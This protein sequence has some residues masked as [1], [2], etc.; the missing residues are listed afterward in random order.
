M[1]FDFILFLVKNEII[2]L[3][4]LGFI[5]S[6]SKLH[7]RFVQSQQNFYLIQDNDSKGKKLPLS[8]LYV[9]D[10]DNFYLVITQEPL[11]LNADLSIAFKEKTPALNTLTCNFKVT[12][13]VKDSDE[14]EDALLFFAVDEEDVKQVLLLSLDSLSDS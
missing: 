11:V 14:Y 5:M 8:Q 1:G 4:L 6:L 13:L 3:P 12:D 2:R 7:V 10:T 9:K